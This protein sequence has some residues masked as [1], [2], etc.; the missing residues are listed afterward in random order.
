MPC[1]LFMLLWIIICPC[2]GDICAITLT[3]LCKRLKLIIINL[4]SSTFFSYYCIAHDN[5]TF[6]GIMWHSLF[7]I[8][9]LGINSFLFTELVLGVDGCIVYENNSAAACSVPF[10]TCSGTGGR[11]HCNTIYYQYNITSCERSKLFVV[12]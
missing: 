10:S 5:H 9:L 4:L 2:P 6:D 8:A 7:L 3:L 12:V 11:C 1:R